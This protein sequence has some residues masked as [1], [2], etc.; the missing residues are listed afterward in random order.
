MAI[1]TAIKDSIRETQE[2]LQQYDIQIPYASQRAVNDT[3]FMVR[4]RF[5]ER[6]PQVLDRPKP[7][8]YKAWRV[9]KARDRNRIKASI[10]IKDPERQAYWHT[11]IGGGE[12]VLR[13]LTVRLHREGKLPRSH[14]LIAGDIKTDSFGNISL[15]RWRKIESKI[16]NKE[17]FVGKLNG[18]STY[19]VFERLKG[20]RNK[21]RVLLFGVDARPA[22]AGIFSLRKEAGNIGEDYR[23]LFAQHH[24]A[25]LKKSREKIRERAL[26]RRGR[27]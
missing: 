19:G 8:I 23:N 25:N 6:G 21:I 17:A 9:E 15:S 3:A 11:A 22:K 4:T 24:A 2:Y 13:A 14:R 20:S 5:A 10:L 27:R 16:N 1:R 26:R 12:G 18:R 7:W